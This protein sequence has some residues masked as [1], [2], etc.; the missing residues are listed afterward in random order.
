[1]KRNLK[2][3]ILFLFLTLIV[4]SLSLISPVWA[5]DGLALM[6]IDPSGRSSGMGG[7]FVS[8]TGDPYSALYNPA[9][10][11][12]IHSF[13]AS[14]SHNEYWKNIRIESGYFSSPFKG[15]FSIHGGL[16]FAGLGDIEVRQTPSS[17]PEA[18]T[19]AH[20]ISFKTG[21]AY[22]VSDKIIAGFGLGWFFE[23]IAAFR[24]SSFNV[25]L[26]VIGKLRSNV[27]V[28]AS[29]TNIG[30]SFSINEAGVSESRKIKLPTTY[31][32]GASYQYQKYLGAGDIVILDDKAHFHMGAEGRL[33]P[34]F[35]IRAGYMFGY[36]TK[37]FTAGA[38]FSHRNMTIDYAFVPYSN[39]LGNSHLFSITFQL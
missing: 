17:E 26:G 14:F 38:S 34:N 8:I 30:S 29:I 31:R 9:G 28:G 2:Q 39:D 15:K 20:D 4:I 12:D 22:K 7:A 10:V 25:D 3:S 19:D 36:D 6:K 23:K 13:T 32:I 21:L 11:G 24:G 35:S 16:R 33:Q 27:A 37:N 1:V 18:Y 5:Q